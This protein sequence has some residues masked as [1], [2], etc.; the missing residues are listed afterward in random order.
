MLDGKAFQIQFEAKSHDN[1]SAGASPIRRPDP[2]KLLAAL[3]ALEEE[4][5]SI[6]HRTASC[7]STRSEEAAA[8]N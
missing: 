8:D 5:R 2:A 4:F 1:L 3:A 6:L 7:P